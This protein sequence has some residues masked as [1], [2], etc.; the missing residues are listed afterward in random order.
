MGFRGKKRVLY[1]C[2]P[3]KVCFFWGGKTCNL[4]KMINKGLVTNNGE[5]SHAEAGR[6]DT[7]RG[8]FYVIA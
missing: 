2:I 8:S 4:H 7:F 3:F 1:I 6:H 5:V